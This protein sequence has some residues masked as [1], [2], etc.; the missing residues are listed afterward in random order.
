M[1]RGS[2]RRRWNSVFGAVRE[3]LMREWDPIG[4]AGD[5]DML[6]EY[7]RYAMSVTGL[8]MNGTYSSSAVKEYLTKVVCESMGLEARPEANDAAVAALDNLR[9]TL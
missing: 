7:D 9:K 1:W 3:I 6:G 8:L 4:V 5:A 2:E